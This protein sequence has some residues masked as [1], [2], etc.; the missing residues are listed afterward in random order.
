MERANLPLSQAPGTDL[1][2]VVVYFHRRPRPADFSLE[3]LFRN[4]RAALPAQVRHR[5]HVARFWSSGFWK[6]VYNVLESPFYQGDVNHVTGDIHYVDFLLPKRRT[7]LTIPDC[8]PLDRLRGWRRAIL[9]FFWYTLPVRRAG[10][11]SVISQATKAEL[12]RHVACDPAKVRVV[13]CC[14]SPGLRRDPRPFNQ[15]CPRVL[16]LGTGKN[17]NLLRVAAALAGMRCHLEIVGRLDDEQRQAL[18]THGI[19]HTAREGLSDAEIAEAYRASDLVVFA[20]TY[21]GFGLPIV[22]ANVT[23]RPVVTSRLL[24]MPEVAGDTACLVDPFDVASIRAGVRRVCEDA[25]YRAQLVEN[26]YRNSARFTPE[27][28]A[29]QYVELYRELLANVNSRTL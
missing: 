24:S 19:Q 29:R 4:V 21:E 15:T 2:G 22:E 20:S 27:A 13:H 5:T 6:R 12:L 7:L 16:H 25:P 10:L 23:G 17:K 28:I 8:A 9:R 1:P 18:Q 11:V 3:Q 14:V 26:G